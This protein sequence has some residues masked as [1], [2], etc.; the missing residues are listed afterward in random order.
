MGFFTYFWRDVEQIMFPT[1]E[2]HE[3]PSMDGALSP[4]DRLD[5]CSP[6]G[7]SIFSADDVVEGPDGA[8]YISGGRQVLRLSGDGYLDRAAFADFEVECRRASHFIQMAGFWFASRPR[9]GCGRSLR[10]TD[11]AS[12]GWRSTAQLS[13]QRHSGAGRQYFCV[14]WKQPERAGR[15][16]H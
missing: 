2:Q 13:D 3:I 10:Q 7:D 14:Q 9:S 6:V 15:L 5:A 16:V 8:L 1:R 4:N 12:S 11:M